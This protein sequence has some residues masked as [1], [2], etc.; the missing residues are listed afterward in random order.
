MVAILSLDCQ[1]TIERHCSVPFIQVPSTA[2]SVRY[3]SLACLSAV[4]NPLHGKEA[5]QGVFL[6]LHFCLRGTCACDCLL[7]FYP[8]IAPAFDPQDTVQLLQMDPYDVA[9]KYHG[10]NKWGYNPCDDR[11]GVC[12]AVHLMCMYVYTCL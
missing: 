8:V 10:S 12:V 9:W 2:K 7:V 1:Y 5:H 11:T 6:G 4:R 3:V